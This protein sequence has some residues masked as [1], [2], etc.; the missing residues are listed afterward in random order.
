MI[1][2]TAYGGYVPFNRLDRKQ[3]AQSFGHPVSSGERAVANADEDSLT[4]SVAAAL[5]CCRGID[6][7]GLNGV[8][9]ATTTSPYK[10]KQGA[11][12]IAAALDLGRNVRTA[13]FA[14]SLR[15]G[16]A[17]MLAALDAAGNG[18]ATLVAIG[19][20]RLGAADGSYE[21]DFGDG[22][23]AFTFDNRGV[24]AEL[25]D[26]YSVAVDF[27]DQWRAQDDRF[28]RNWDER[29]SATQAYE[30][31]V[32]EAIK[33]VLR[34]TGLKPEDFA[35]IVNYGSTPRY[36]AGIAAKLGFGPDQIQDN[37]S[38]T[39]GNA[40]AASAPMMLVAALETAKPGDRILFVTYGEGSDAIVF[41][42]TEEIGRLA[43]RRGIKSYLE[44]KRVTMNYQKYLRWRDLVAFE[45]AKRPA[46]PRSSLPDFYRNYKKNYALYGCRCTECGTPQFPPTRVCVQCQAVDKMAP[47]R[48]YGREGKVVTFVF[49]YLALS[50]DPPNVDVV[51][52][53]EGGGRIFCNLVDCEPEQV[54]VGLQIEMCYRKLFT[55]DGIHTYFWKAV[56]KTA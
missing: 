20:C 43:P 13:D 14:D 44:H 6:A 25:V 9:F 21:T 17:A 23:A 32:A 56:P 55:A 34:K 50:A 24:I 53:F 5:E 48:F 30:P 52:D 28:V 40:G 8:Y 1:G 4:M 3:I 45:P 51:V 2:I 18:A 7:Q 49:D 15:A 22:A 54:K 19:D 37:L 36:Q 16:S 11:T 26:S 12:N 42:V 31:F 38:K 39:I 47:Y 35:K 33:G 41:Q 46:Q 27:L 10:E 29:F